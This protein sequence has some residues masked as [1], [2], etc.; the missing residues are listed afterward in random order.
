M[1]VTGVFNLWVS[2][3]FLL[4]LAIALF[5]SKKS[6]WLSHLC[7]FH[8]LAGKWA[9]KERYRTPADGPVRCFHPLAGKWAEKGNP[10]PLQEIRNGIVSI[11]L[12]GNDRK[13]RKAILPA[14]VSQLFCFHPLAGKWSEKCYL[15]LGMLRL[16][17]LT[18]PSPCGEMIGKAATDLGSNTVDE[19]VSIPLRG[20]DRK[21]WPPQHHAR[22]RAVPRAFPSPCGEMI[23]KVFC[24]H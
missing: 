6:I 18:F 1:P 10:L 17:F 23:G 2:Y 15:R 3:Y 8:P 19:G 14:W 7:R 21:R 11:P 13:S 24:L 20:N 16:R 12:R 9:E 4:V 5:T 22:L